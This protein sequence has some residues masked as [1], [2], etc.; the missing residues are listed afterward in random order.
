M[1]K[2]KRD[3]W[4][5]ESSTADR[6]IKAGLRAKR[7]EN[8]AEA[9][10]V[11]LLAHPDLAVE[12][13]RRRVTLTVPEWIRNSKRRHGRSWVIHVHHGDMRT[14]SALGRFVI[15]DEDLWFDILKAGGKLA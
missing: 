11:L 2:P 12:C 5:H 4:Q 15:L 6:Y 9:F 10:D 14:N 1:N 8:N 7:N 3:S 13:K